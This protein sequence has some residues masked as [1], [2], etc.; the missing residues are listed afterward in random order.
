MIQKHKD[1]IT[2]LEKELANGADE[3]T[4][5]KDTTAIQAL[6]TLIADL[7]RDLTITV[8][9]TIDPGFSPI[10]LNK[11]SEQPVEPLEHQTAIDK[12]GLIAIL[13]PSES[14]N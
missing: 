5:K 2:Q 3:Q 13:A 12:T 8:K 1:Q 11:N 9:Q 6:Q 4:Q 7:Q 14:P 10:D